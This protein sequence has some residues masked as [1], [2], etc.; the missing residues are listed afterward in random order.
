MAKVRLQAGAEFDLLNKD[1]LSSALS[2]Q[3]TADQLARLHGIKHMRLP[4][5]LVGTV[6]SSAISLDGNTGPYPLGPRS[7][8]AWAIKRLIVSGLTS[9]ATPDVVNLYKG[10]PGAGVPLWQFNGNNFGYTFGKLEMTLYGGETLS[11]KNSGSIAATG[12]ISLGGEL[13]ECPAELIGKL[14]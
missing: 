5:V 2:D 10:G 14:A 3:S 4:E 1:E 7:G 13:I 9:G 6:A 12:Q 8:Y 11:L